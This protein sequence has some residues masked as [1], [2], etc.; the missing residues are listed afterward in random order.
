MTVQIIKLAVSHIMKAFESVN[1]SLTVRFIASV[2]KVFFK[3]RV[4]V[5]LAK[6]AHGT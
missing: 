6:E 3:K 5:L 4:Y 2:R 1:T